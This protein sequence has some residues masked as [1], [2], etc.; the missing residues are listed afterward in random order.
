[1]KRVFKVLSVPV[2]LLLTAGLYLLPSAHSKPREEKVLICHKPG[3][4]AEKELLVAASAVDG[5]LDPGDFIGTC[6]DNPG[7]LPPSKGL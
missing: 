7:N 2:G 4:S 5:H 6:A 1:M 3:T